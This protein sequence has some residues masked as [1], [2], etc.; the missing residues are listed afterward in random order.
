MCASQKYLQYA[1]INRTSDSFRGT[2]VLRRDGI[3]AD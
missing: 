3:S 1:H 2:T